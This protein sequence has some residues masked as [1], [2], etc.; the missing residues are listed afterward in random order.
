MGAGDG[1]PETDDRPAGRSGPAHSTHAAQGHER[2][3]A[4]GKKF[5][6][7]S[8]L[9]KSHTQTLSIAYLLCT[10]YRA[11]VYIISWPVLPSTAHET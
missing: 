11:V 4:P 3:S 1:G 10:L 7:L 5:P 2:N 9:F 6:Q 8:S